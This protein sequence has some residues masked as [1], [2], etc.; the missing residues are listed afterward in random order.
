MA[1]LS[2]IDEKQM[3][4]EYA[5]HGRVHQIHDVL[6]D[7]AAHDGQGKAERPAQAGRSRGWYKTDY[8]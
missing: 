2:F 1:R 7:H 5:Q 8:A 3:T 6:R 4:P